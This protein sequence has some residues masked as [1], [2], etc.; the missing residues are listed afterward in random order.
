[1]IGNDSA[2]AY[3]YKQLTN[4]KIWVINT[5]IGGTNLAN[6]NPTEKGISYVNAVSLFQKAEQI[7]KN[8]ITAGHY[9]L[10]HLGVVNHGAE[11][12]DQL[13][14]VTKYKTAFEAMWNGFKT[15]LAYDFDGDGRKETFD[16]L[17][18]MPVSRAYSGRF[19]TDPLYE[20]PYEFNN[21]QV[22]NYYMAYF[23][24]PDVIIGNTVG[25][26]WLTDQA[27]EAYFKK[28]QV[29]SFYTKNHKG[30]LPDNPTVMRNGVFGDGVHHNQLGYNITGIQAIESMC[31]YWAGTNNAT[32]AKLV[33]ED[34]VT[35][36]V[37][38][39]EKPFVLDKA[40]SVR[41][42][43][44][45]QSGVK[46][47]A[48]TSGCITYEYPCTVR[49][50]GE[51]TG[52]LTIKSA[53]GATL[54]TVVFKVGNGGGSQVHVCGNGILVTGKAATCTQTGMKNYY[55]C[56]CG[57]N[58]VEQACTTLISDVNTWAVIPALNH[59]FTGAYGGFDESSHW[60]VCNRAGC[61]VTDQPQPHYGGTATTTAQ[62]V[63]EGCKAPYGTLQAA[64]ID[65]STATVTLEKSS[66]NY[67]GTAKQ[68][69]VTVKLKKKT[70]V[71]D[72]DYKVSYSNHIMVG[73]ATVTI[74]GKGKYTGKAKA[75]FQI[76]PAKVSLKTPTTKKGQMTVTWT[77]NAKQGASYKIQ[78]STTKTFESKKSVTVT[79]PKTGSKTIKDLKSGKTYYVRIRAYKQ[80][81]GKTYTGSWSTVRYVKIK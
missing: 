17:T 20:N 31:K 12:G 63:C 35:E 72:V 52:T 75:T 29:S 44:V 25:R 13:W 3:R 15:D 57:K 32:L 34:G 47:I 66:Y 37:G 2:I 71:K 61:I 67:S 28:H 30:K 62:A 80:V 65:L 64:P 76:L 11:N 42:I 55:K 33:L 45:S 51:G 1:M 6:W 59:D 69:K 43:P 8:E 16:C 18:V 22:A 26:E 48:Q 38:T 36:A 5:G 40:G 58:Y 7:M 50:T 4:E 54:T 81:A 24:M 56:S 21:G 70:L 27:V 14:D 53:T 23:G 19:W 46:L 60:H 41:M 77:A 68:P 49:A 9:T 39:S 79:S 73:K 10:R 78:Y 74:T